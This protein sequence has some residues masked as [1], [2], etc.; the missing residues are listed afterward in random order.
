MKIEYKKNLLQLLV[1]VSLFWNI[2]MHSDEIFQF[3]HLWQWQLE[4]SV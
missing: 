4:I 3:Y 2:C 1:L